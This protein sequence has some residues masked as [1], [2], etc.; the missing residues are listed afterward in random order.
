M[1]IGF[2]LGR[3]LSLNFIRMIMMVFGTVFALVYTIDLVELLRRAGD[4]PNATAALMAQLALFR[5]PGG[6]RAGVPL[7]GAVREHGGAAAA[8]PQARARRSRARP[9]SRRGSSSSP[10]SWS[11]R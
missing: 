10:A 2:T 11:R 1:M 4:A 8:Q 9:E 5:T 6:R 3:Y 7:R